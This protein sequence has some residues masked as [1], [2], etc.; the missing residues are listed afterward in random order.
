MPKSDLTTCLYCW[1]PKIYN[2][3]ECNA[4]IC[5]DHTILIN[6]LTFCDTNCF[7]AYKQK[8]EL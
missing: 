4:R 5:Y 7:I 1:Q 2:C 3:S 6:K 8:N